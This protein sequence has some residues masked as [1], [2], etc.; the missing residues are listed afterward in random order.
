MVL[1]MLVVI[2]KKAIVETRKHKEVAVTEK[3]VVDICGYK[4]EETMV[5]ELIC[6]Y[7]EAAVVETCCYRVEET[8]A[9]D[10]EMHKSIY[11]L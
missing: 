1:L 11:G 8:L 2:K 10:V 3:M 4:E 7:N 5:E 9:M 6:K